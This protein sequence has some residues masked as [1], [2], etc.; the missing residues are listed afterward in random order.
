MQTFLGRWRKFTSTS[1]RVSDSLTSEGRAV[2]FNREISIPLGKAVNALS[3]NPFAITGCLP[4]GLTDSNL[5]I[6][7]ELLRSQAQSC[8]AVPKTTAIG[9]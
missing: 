6:V 9:S 3:L 2:L 5:T 8:S 1:P 7:P 4:L